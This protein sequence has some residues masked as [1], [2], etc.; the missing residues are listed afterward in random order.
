[1]AG[2]RRW[3]PAAAVAMSLTVLVRAQDTAPRPID[4]LEAYAVYASLL[5]DEWTV[6]DAHAKQLVFQRET[7]PYSRCMPSGAPMTTDWKQT[8]DAYRAENAGP[9]AMREGFGLG[10]PYV[11]I[12]RADIQA[13]FQD[14]AAPNLGW[15]GFY[16]RFPDSGG[17]M[18]VSAVGFNADKTRAMAYIGHGCGSLCGGGTHHLLEKTD[19]RWREVRPRG[20]SFCMWAS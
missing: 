14:R 18:M 6:R 12:S 8:V 10:L 2:A 19:G 17:Y 9:R 11:V 4:D 16:K 7:D 13:T 1:M 15:D 20:V 5:P 3:L